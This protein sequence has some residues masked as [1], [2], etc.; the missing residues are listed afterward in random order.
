MVLNKWK[1]NAFKIVN[2]TLIA[3][4]EYHLIKK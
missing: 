4:W 1:R 3:D 2:V